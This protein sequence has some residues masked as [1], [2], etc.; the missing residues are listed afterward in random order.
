ML[1][2]YR[3]VMKRY[4]HKLCMQWTK[5]RIGGGT[6]SV[7]T[8]NRPRLLGE[9]FLVNKQRTDAIQ[10]ESES[11]GNIISGVNY[12]TNWCLPRR[13]RFS[14]LAINKNKQ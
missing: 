7:T 4:L 10:S 11:V 6:F 9:R 5:L 1:V 14:L 8:I 13:L 2:L 12:L 3:N